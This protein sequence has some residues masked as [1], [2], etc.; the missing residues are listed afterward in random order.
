[1]PLIPGADLLLFLAIITVKKAKSGNDRLKLELDGSG[2]CSAG[3][4]SYT[5]SFDGQL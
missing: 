4:G 1:M 3:G 5:W 2:L